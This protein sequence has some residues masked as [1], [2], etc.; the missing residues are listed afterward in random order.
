LKYANK[1][2]LLAK[3]MVVLH[4]MFVR[5]LGIARRYGIEMNVQK[6][7]LMIISRQPSPVQ[8]MI[9]K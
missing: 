5:Q 8:I 7:R 4:G 1:L 2:G 6:I 3:E 9:K